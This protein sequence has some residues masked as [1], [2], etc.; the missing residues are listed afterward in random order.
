MFKLL[1]EIIE[2]LKDIRIDLIHI[3]WELKKNRE[4]EK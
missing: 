4:N 3:K 2:L 1:R